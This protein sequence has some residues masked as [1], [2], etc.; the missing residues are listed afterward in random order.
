MASARYWPRAFRAHALLSE[1]RT[2]LIADVVTGKSRCAR[3]QRR[4]CRTKP[5]SRS[6]LEETRYPSWTTGE[7]E[8]TDDLNAVPEEAEV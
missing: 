7:K 4:G 1:Y 3:R 2:R 8:L 5:R 6:Q